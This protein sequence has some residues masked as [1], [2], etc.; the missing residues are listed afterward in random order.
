MI[1]PIHLGVLGTSRPGNDA[2][3][4][5]S[6]RRLGTILSAD[7]MIVLTGACGGYPDALAAGFRSHGGHVVGYSPGRDLDDH[8]AGGSPVDN[9]DEMLFGFG[10]LIERQVALVRRAS[11]VLALGGN[12]GTLSELCIAVK[13]KKPM[14]L[15]QGFPGIGPHFMELLDQLTVYPTPRVRLVSIDDAAEAVTDFATEDESFSRGVG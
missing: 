2:R 3:S 10:G 11:V 15:V 1:S 5:E 7:R 13:M 12:V 8:V 4:I 9:C 14:V 6:A